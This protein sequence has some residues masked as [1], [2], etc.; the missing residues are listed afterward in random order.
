VARQAGTITSWTTNS[1]GAGAHYVIKIFRRTPD[2]DVFQV[3]A[4]ASSVLLSSG[5]NTVPVKLPVESGDMLGLNESN[6]AN[7]CTFPRPGDNVISRTGNLADGSS[8]AF[9]AV[10]DV[11]LNLSA[12]LVP[13]N[14]FTLGGITRDRKRG[15]AS[16][17]A[18][19]S[20]PGI[21]Q[22]SGKGLKKR[23]SKSLPIAG[24]VSL[25]LATVGKT[26]HR[27]ARKGKVTITPTV[28]FSPAGGDPS[29]QSIHLKLSEVRQPTVPG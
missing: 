13:D 12:V 28:T 14:G 16:I 27:L 4:H 20:N 26:H 3:M 10:N 7:S 15:T 19:T 21:V 6:G 1:S 29:S 24:P 22:L 25:G 8:G 18:T 5:I 9:G 17:T 11:R 2:P 23:G